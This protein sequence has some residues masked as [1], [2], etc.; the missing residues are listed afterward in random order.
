MLLFFGPQKGRSGR[1]YSDRHY[2]FRLWTFLAVS[3]GEFNFLAI[4]QC[5]E[6]IAFDSA[7]MYEDVGAAFLFNKPKA[8]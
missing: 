5:F 8:L 2:I 1:F 6:S 3:N 4:G 7:E